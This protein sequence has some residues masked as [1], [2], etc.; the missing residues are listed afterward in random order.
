MNAPS[1]RIAA[2]LGFS[3]L[4]NRASPLTA[5]PAG[6]HAVPEGRDPLH[7]A[8]RGVRSSARGLPPA[9]PAPLPREEGSQASLN[10]AV[11]ALPPFS[12]SGGGVG[13]RGTP[14]GV[15]S[16]VSRGTRRRLVGGDA[17]SGRCCPCRRLVASCLG[18]LG[19]SEQ[20]EAWVQRF[21]RVCECRLPRGRQRGA[22][23]N[24]PL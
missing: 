4:P 20:L 14:L 10:P 13:G 5:V 7:A 17:Q 24:P 23:D 19:P 11:P 16:S 3:A 9:V 15:P 6:G 12:V 21:K 22:A 8:R 2:G 1:C 18:F